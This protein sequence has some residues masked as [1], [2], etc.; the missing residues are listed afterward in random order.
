MKQT[1]PMKNVI[2]CYLIA[3]CGLFGLIV[4]AMAQSAADDPVTAEK[5][6]EP[7]SAQMSHDLQNLPWKSFKAVVASVPKLAAGVDA[8]GP[9]GWEFVRENY[10]TYNWTKK[11]DKLDADQKKQLAERIRKARTEPD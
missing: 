1:I 4:P 7:D 9:L 10:A 11:I 3:L 8:Y 2:L 5:P 6:A